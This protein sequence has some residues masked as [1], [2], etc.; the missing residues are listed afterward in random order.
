MKKPVESKRLSSKLEAA[1]VAPSGKPSLSDYTDAF[2][3]TCESLP[4][5]LVAK[6]IL[7]AGRF[8]AHEHAIWRHTMP[9]KRLPEHC[10]FRISLDYRCGY[11]G[12]RGTPTC[13]NCRVSPRAVDRRARTWCNVLTGRISPCFDRRDKTTRYGRRPGCV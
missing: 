7:A 5:T 12:L 13:S 11:R 10:R 2:R 9:I 3:K 6:A 8:A 1:T 4:P